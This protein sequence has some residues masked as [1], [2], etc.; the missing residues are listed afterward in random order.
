MAVGT[1]TT[2]NQYNDATDVVIV[3]QIQNSSMALAT[4]LRLKE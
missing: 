1:G 3:I 2:T 4:R